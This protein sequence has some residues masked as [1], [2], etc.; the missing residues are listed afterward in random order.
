MLEGMRARLAALEDTLRAKLG[1]SSP[2]GA[3]PG[4]PGKQQGGGKD[5]QQQQRTRTPDSMRLESEEEEE[6][7]EPPPEAVESPKRA[8]SPQVC[9]CDSLQTPSTCQ[10]GVQPHRRSGY[11]HSPCLQ[12]D[13]LSNCIAPGIMCC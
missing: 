3:K 11:C 5:G 13:L 6:D 2:S 1:T 7:E 12:H 9:G 10:A 4:A 8:T